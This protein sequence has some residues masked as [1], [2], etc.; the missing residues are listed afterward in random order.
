MQIYLSTLTE[1]D[2][3][4]SLDSIEQS[5]DNDLETS[6]QARARVKKLRKLPNYN[7]ELEVI[8]KDEHNDVVGHILLIEVQIESSTQTYNTLIIASLSVKPELRGQK[9]GRGLV[10]AAEERAKDQRYSTIIVDQCEEY[11]KQLGYQPAKNYNIYHENNDS[12]VLIK[13][14]NE[15]LANK[16]QGTIKFPE[17]FN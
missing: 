16:P 15:D 4:N 12:P 3:E 13:F 1:V 17:N 2:Y 6:W 5:Y 11:F 14:L 9:L 7:F 10:Q 8:A